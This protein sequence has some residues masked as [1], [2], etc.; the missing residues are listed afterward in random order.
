M[1]WVCAAAA[2]GVPVIRK[3]VNEIANIAFISKAANLKIGTT[4][5][6]EYLDGIPHERLRQQFVPT[7]PTLWEIDNYQQFLQRRRDLIADGINDVV[8]SLR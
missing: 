2:V 3:D 4:P 7:D 8:T 1:Y 6:A 5:P